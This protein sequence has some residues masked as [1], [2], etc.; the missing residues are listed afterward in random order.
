M[1]WT[2]LDHAKKAVRY[3][4]SQSGYKAETQFAV[5]RRIFAN[6]SFRIYP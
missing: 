6:T 2:P 4:S 5:V 1:L 3:R